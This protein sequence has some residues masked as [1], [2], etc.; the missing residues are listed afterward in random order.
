MWASNCGG[1]DDRGADIECL[2]CR[3]SQDG[4]PQDP[5]ADPA[6]S[7][8]ILLVTRD[9]IARNDPAAYEVLKHIET[10]GHSSTTGPH[11]R[12]TEFRV[13]EHN[14]LAAPGRG[15]PIIIQCFTATA[16]LVGQ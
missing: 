5:S 4:S 14:L 1:W 9:I 12:Y 6:D 7:I 10:P 15:A 2:V 8:L 13:P 11:V 16:S 3:Y